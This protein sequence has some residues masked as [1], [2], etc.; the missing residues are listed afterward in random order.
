MYVVITGFDI[1]TCKQGKM[2]NKHPADDCKKN[3]KEKAFPYCFISHCAV[4]VTDKIFK[5][6][7]FTSAVRFVDLR[8]GFYK[9]ISYMK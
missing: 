6:N 9:A 5:R 4:P 1:A 7:Y 2:Q 8:K 3:E